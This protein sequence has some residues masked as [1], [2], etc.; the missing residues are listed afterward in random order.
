MKPKKF[1]KR[2]V[3]SLLGLIIVLF[4]V[5]AYTAF[6]IVSGFGAKNLC[7]NAFLSNRTADDVLQNELGAFPLSIGSFKLNYDDSSATASVLGLAKKKA[8][9]RPGLGCTLTNGVSEEEIRS[10]AFD[11]PAFPYGKDSLNWP[12]GNLIPAYDSLD[13]NQV[14]LDQAIDNY[15]QEPNP[16]ELR[17]TR[18]VVVLH[19]GR[20]IAER[21]AHGFDQH[22][23]QLSWSMAKSLT[24][25]LVGILVKQGKLDIYEHAD[26]EEWAGPEDPRQNITLDQLLRMSSGLSWSEIYAL[27]SSATNMLFRDADMGATAADQ[28]LEY[29]PDEQWYYSSG[30]S[31]IIA[32]IVKNTVGAE[33]Y[34]AFV[35]RELFHKIGIS[36]AVFEP[37]G[38]GT[39]VGSSYLYMTPRDFARFGQ[40]LLND[41]IW[42]GERIL[43]EGWVDYSITPTPTSPNGNYGA[44]F[45]LN[46]QGAAFPDAPKD[47]YYANGFQDQ[48]IIVVPS[49][50]LVLV[51]LGYTQTD[52]FDFNGL[53]KG[54]LEA[55]D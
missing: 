38:S 31:N 11:K 23:R 1:L 17:I 42:E 12:V 20:L 22:T 7:S 27:P 6:P 13:H 47:T 25:A 14:Q 21:Y 55:L 9:F 41:G 19:K 53:L 39:F 4:V 8:I 26:V 48:A 3:I 51:R 28:E 40:L 5:A 32:R 30:T 35:H 54:V 10:V 49:K 45:W 43:P 24:N 29:E 46:S 52:N 37:D 16:E 15:F 34:W 33:N 2:L 50:E 44:Q 36:S 18:G